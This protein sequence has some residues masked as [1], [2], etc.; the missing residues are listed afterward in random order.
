MKPR[1]TK[2]ELADQQ[3][4]RI[5]WSDG[6]SRCYSFR[7]LIDNCPCASCREKRAGEA[8]KAEASGDL[9]TVIPAAEA[10]PLKLASVEPVGSYAYNIFFHGRCRNGI[11][12]FEHLRQLGDVEAE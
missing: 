7:D 10:Q 12:T 4:L 2:I 3:H 1:P 8:D 6:Q 9:L 5:A 11:Y